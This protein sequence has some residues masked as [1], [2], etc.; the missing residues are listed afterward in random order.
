LR[1]RDDVP[2]PA[3]VLE[4][5]L[6]AFG[7][8]EAVLEETVLRLDDVRVVPVRDR[9]ARV[10]DRVEDLR[11]PVLLRDRREVRPDVA[12]PAEEGVAGRAARGV[13]EE[14]SCASIRLAGEI[15]DG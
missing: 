3:R 6:I 4:D 2:P 14:D 11:L 13:A 9:R 7:E 15:E 5:D 12:A 10:Q 1:R 8:E